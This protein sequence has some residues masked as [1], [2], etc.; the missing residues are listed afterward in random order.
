MT[1]EEIDDLVDLMRAAGRETM[2]MPLSE[3]REMMA[4]RIGRVDKGEL[5]KGKIKP[6]RYQSVSRKIAGNKKAERAAARLI[7]NVEVAKAKSAG[8][9]S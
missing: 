6:V 3:W 5:A 1:L 9:K 7:R 8:E 4:A 2:P